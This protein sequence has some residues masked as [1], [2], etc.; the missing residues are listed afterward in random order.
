MK[1]A[2][3]SVLS[4]L[5]LFSIMSC[6]KNNDIDNTITQIG[7]TPFIVTVVERIPQRGII[8]WTQSTNLGNADT[9][10]Y[11]VFINGRM[12]DSNLLK[13]K[14]TLY[15]LSGDT[16][17]VGKV[18]AYNKRGDTISAPFVFDKVQ[19]FIAFNSEKYFEMYNLSSGIRMW[20]KIW[21]IY[22]YE[23]GSPTIVNDTIYF[24]N[25]NLSIGNTLFSYNF[26]TGKQ[27]WSAIPY[28]GI[29]SNLAEYTNPVY[30]NNKIV[31][32][33][34]YGIVALNAKTG[35]T[36]WT[37]NHP[38]NR[39]T[40]TPVVTNN[41]VFVG[42]N[43]DFVAVDENT[44]IPIWHFPIGPSAKRPLCINNL[45]VLETA[46]KIYALD[47]NSGKTIWQKALSADFSPVI[48]DS[49][50]ITFVSG[51][52]IYGLS[53]TTGNTVWHSGADWLSGI[54]LTVGNGNCYFT[55]Y[56]NNKIVALKSKTGKQIWET[57][58]PGN[59]NLIFAKNKLFTANS[60]TVFTYNANNG[61]LITSVYLSRLSHAIGAF[62]IQLNDTTY[63][64]NEHGNYK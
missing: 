9:I 2:F 15:N 56:G 55:D 42:G 36:L 43:D 52:G 39:A 32:A 20:N 22:T 16:M 57:T 10:N 37:Y 53:P 62:T 21:N 41:K 59:G 29:N 50:L 40:S 33:T 48:S 30:S 5:V 12:A 28:T 17:Y 27:I 35:Q 34:Q 46:G 26:K 54:S 8:S 51:D 3:F 64:S 23:D 1:F 38:H 19:E 49:V 11:K 45:I 7:L 4:A 24:S 18:I 60:N 63:Y 58:N 25:K 61:S 14:D 31:V 47:Q 13:T 44:G 6:T